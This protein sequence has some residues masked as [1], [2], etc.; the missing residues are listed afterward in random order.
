MKTQTNVS[1]V[2]P[3][4][5]KDSFKVAL[6]HGFKGT[7]GMMFAN[8]CALAAAAV[9]DITDVT[10]YAYSVSPKTRGVIF[11]LFAMKLESSGVYTSAV[12]V[13]MYF[14][15][16]STMAE[17]VVI[18]SPDQY[19]S[20]H[21]HVPEQTF[22]ASQ[23][24]SARLKSLIK[25]YHGGSISEHTIFSNQTRIY[26][27]KHEWDAYN[28]PQAT[29]D[30]YEKACGSGFDDSGSDDVTDQADPDGPFSVR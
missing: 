21:L 4:L 10:A 16:G 11:I 6:D 1:E 19:A 2:S 26:L 25:S 7:E 8:K 29:Y 9:C 28:D 14:D 5:N 3:V 24:A 13:M 17:H 12:S 23:Y 27:E 22:N 15:N 30:S 20:T 18:N